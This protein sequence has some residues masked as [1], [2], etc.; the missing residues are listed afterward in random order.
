M[1]IGSRGDGTVARACQPGLQ[2]DVLADGGEQVRAV[3]RDRL[4]NLGHEPA[5][6]REP[7]T[8]LD[9][10]DLEA[11]L[12]ER[13]RRLLLT[14]AERRRDGEEVAHEQR[15]HLGDDDG[16]ALERSDAPR[17]LVEPA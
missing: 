1:T 17:L 5:I 16:V 13:A 8:D 2:R 4:Q 10:E 11:L 3:G 14:L 6:G 15:E 9:N 12:A 7:P